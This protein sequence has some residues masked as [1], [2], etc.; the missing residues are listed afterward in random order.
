M[1]IS[2]QTLCLFDGIATSDLPL[3]ADREHEL[4][5]TRRSPG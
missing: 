1:T 3:G 5:E 4:L 2:A